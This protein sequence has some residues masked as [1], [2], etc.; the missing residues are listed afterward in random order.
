MKELREAAGWVVVAEDEARGTVRHSEVCGKRRKPG[1]AR[2]MR[3]R[4]YVT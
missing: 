1:S 2:F 3:G 4:R